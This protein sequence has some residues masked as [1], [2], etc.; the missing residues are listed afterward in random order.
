MRKDKNRI[1]ELKRVIQIVFG[2]VGFLLFFAPILLGGI[3]NI[4][5]IAGLLCF[6]GLLA[7]GLFRPKILPRLQ[8][9]RKTKKG[10]LLTSLFCVLFCCGL[11]LCCALR[12]RS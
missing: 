3:F 11:L 8:T 12:F 4:G 10:R 1:F 7:W 2:G 5:T 6:G 9:L